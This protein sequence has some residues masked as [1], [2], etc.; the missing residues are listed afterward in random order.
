MRGSMWLAV[1]WWEYHEYLG[2]LK[3]PMSTKKGTKEGN[4]APLLVGPGAR[5]KPAGWENF[6]G[7]ISNAVSSCFVGI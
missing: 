4:N 3:K 6:L 1:R 5:V 7:G 2:L